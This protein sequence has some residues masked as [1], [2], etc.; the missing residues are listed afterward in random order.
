[1]D[2]VGWVTWC[3]DPRS[4]AVMWRGTSDSSRSRGQNSRCMLG[5]EPSEKLSELLL[6]AVVG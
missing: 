2:L 3:L 5:K 6:R 1:M 4:S